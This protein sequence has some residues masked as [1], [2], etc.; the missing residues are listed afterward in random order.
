MKKHSVGR[1]ED[2]R[3]EGK[4]EEEGEREKGQEKEGGEPRRSGSSDASR[5]DRARARGAKTR[6]GG[7][8]REEGAM[9]GGGSEREGGQKAYERARGNTIQPDRS[10]R[11]LEGDIPDSCRRAWIILGPLLDLAAPKKR[12]FS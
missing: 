5:K 1:V 7:R 8:G 2:T 12:S 4:T 10:L 3:R 9:A 6:D 11:A